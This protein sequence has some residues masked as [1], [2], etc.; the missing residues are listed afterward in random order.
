MKRILIIGSPGAGKTTFA[1]SLQEK[2]NLPLVHLDNLFWRDNWKCVK[3]EEF[4]SLLQK[5]LEKENWIIDGNYNRTLRHRMNYCDTVFYFDFSTCSCLWGITKRLIKNYGKT[6]VDIGGNCPERLD[7]QKIS[8]Y[9]S[10]FNFN[11]QHRKE[12]RELL[13]VRSKSINVV[14]FKNRRQVKEY[15]ENL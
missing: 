1:L 15:L 2:L 8:F 5:E 11:R 10:V 14:I 9:K 7:L 4:D 13:S 3:R 12:Y 6:R